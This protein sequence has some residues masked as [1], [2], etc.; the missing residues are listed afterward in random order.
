MKNLFDDDYIRINDVSWRYGLI[1]IIALILLIV[2]LNVLKKDYYYQ[3][4]ISFIESK[5]AILIVNKEN[6]NK[7]KEQ[8]EVILNNVCLNYNIEKIEEI[9]DTYY[10]NVIFDYEVEKIGAITYKIL[11]KKEKYIDYFIRIIKGGT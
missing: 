6:I 5:K 4:I 11:L 7:L 2:I 3:N 10:V 1:L 8:H 9:D